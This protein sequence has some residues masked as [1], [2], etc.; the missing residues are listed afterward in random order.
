MTLVDFVEIKIFVFQLYLT[1]LLHIE[2]L[3]HNY[4]KKNNDNIH[5][6]TCV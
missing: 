4:I 1:I 6:I 3:I 2:Y 5:T